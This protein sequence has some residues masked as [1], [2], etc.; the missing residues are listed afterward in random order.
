MVGG[1]VG[2]YIRVGVYTAF[3]HFFF[4]YYIPIKS[5]CILTHL[6]SFSIHYRDN[7]NI[8]RLLQSSSSVSVLMSFPLLHCAPSTWLA[9]AWLLWL[10][11]A[12]SKPIG[13]WGSDSTLCMVGSSWRDGE[14]GDQDTPGPAPETRERPIRVL[15]CADKPPLLRAEN[16]LG[17]SVGTWVRRGEMRTISGIC[18]GSTKWIFFL[19]IQSF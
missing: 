16:Q 17:S 12:F 3:G 6:W 7:T 2:R 15:L 11:A 19:G 18:F 10:T 4:T 14:R 1:R 13:S 8:L 5:A 9:R